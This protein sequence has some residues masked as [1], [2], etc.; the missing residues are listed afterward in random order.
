MRRSPLEWGTLPRWLQPFWRHPP[1]GS[2]D[3]FFQGQA[4]FV[5]SGV[6]AKFGSLLVLVFQLVK[7]GGK[8][9]T[10]SHGGHL[11]LAGAPAREF[12]DV[13][14]GALLKVEKAAQNTEWRAR[15]S[16]ACCEAVE[17]AP[18]AYELSS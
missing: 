18:A 6:S 11:D 15:F 13:P 16:Q 1:G 5:I 7:V 3:C 14:Y 10:G 9:S 2:N 8:F 17:A 4:W 12:R